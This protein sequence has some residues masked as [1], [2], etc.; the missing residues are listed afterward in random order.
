MPDRVE[1]DLGQ[2]QTQASALLAA[3]VGEGSEGVGGA[4]THEVQGAGADGE[5]P[6]FVPAGSVRS[7]LRLNSRSWCSSA[8]TTW[9]DRIPTPVTHRRPSTRA[10]ATA[11]SYCA[12]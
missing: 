9:H 5:A 8:Q 10:F 6:A 4:V 7:R 1:G 11:A 12:G 2:A 3:L